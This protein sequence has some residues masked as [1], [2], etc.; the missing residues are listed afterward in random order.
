MTDD[1]TKQFRSALSKSPVTRDYVAYRGIAPDLL[2]SIAKLQPGQTASLRSFFR[3][4]TSRSSAEKFGTALMKI[5]IPAGAR[6]ISLFAY[7]KVSG[8][9][10]LDMDQTMTFLGAGEENEFQ[11]SVDVPR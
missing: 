3:V 6:A 4:C 1:E 5:K 8:D 10:V 2:L 9:V 11:F 7:S